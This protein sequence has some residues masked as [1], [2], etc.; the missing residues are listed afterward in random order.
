MRL[1]DERLSSVFV[2]HYRAM[3]VIGFAALE[4]YDS[5]DKNEKVHFE[6]KQDL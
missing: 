6:S 1:R 4:I 3:A 2:R 5:Y